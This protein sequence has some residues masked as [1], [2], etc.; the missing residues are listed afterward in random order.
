MQSLLTTFL[1]SHIFLI[2]KK[3]AVFRDAKCP[4][5]PEPEV[6]SYP[7]ERPLLEQQRTTLAGIAVRVLG[8]T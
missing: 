8:T 4:S 7:L 1:P 3:A 5:W 6:L 2:A